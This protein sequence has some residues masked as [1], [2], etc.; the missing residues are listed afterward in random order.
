MCPQVT[1]CHLVMNGETL[2]ETGVRDCIQSCSQE[3]PGESKENLPPQKENGPG[4]TTERPTPWAETK[5]EL[6]DIGAPL[7]LKRSAATAFTDSAQDLQ[8]ALCQRS[9]TYTEGAELIPYSEY[10]R[11]LESHKHFHRTC[12][13]C[14]IVFLTWNNTF[15]FCEHC[16][17]TLN[18]CE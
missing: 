16:E 18:E 2:D 10:R 17:D 1:L 3:M 7:P 5:E 9:E 13:R 12:D 14:A 8:D 6:A 11:G 4:A 15:R